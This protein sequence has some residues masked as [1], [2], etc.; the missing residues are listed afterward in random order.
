MTGPT[1]STRDMIDDALWLAE[2]G[3][4]WP[5]ICRRLGRQPCTLYAAFRRHG[6]DIPPGLQVEEAIYTERLRAER[7]HNRAA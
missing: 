7:R 2:M 3:E 1:T 6:I 5:I 4:S